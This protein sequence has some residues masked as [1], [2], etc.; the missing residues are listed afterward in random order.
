MKKYYLDPTDGF[1]YLCSKKINGCNKWDNGNTCLECN[2]EF[3]LDENN[4]CIHL[5][6][7]SKYYLDPIT[8][9][10]ASCSKIENCEECSSTQCLK[11]KSRFK[12]RNSIC[13]KDENN[14]KYKAI[15]IAALIISII[16]LIGIVIILLLLLRNNLFR[17]QNLITTSTNEI[18]G[19]VEGESIEVKKR[20]EAFIMK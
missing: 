1:Y 14:D 13:E 5:S 2:S 20:K 4:K 11:C 6:E 17:S 10:Y 9:R 18:N 19:D 8:L 7:R 15:V 3:G 16:A 12:L